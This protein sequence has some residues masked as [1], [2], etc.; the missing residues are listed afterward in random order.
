MKKNLFIFWVQIHQTRTPENKPTRTQK[1]AISD[2]NK[3]NSM[4]STN[5]K[6]VKRQ[7]ISWGETSAIDT[8]NKRSAPR[9]CQEVLYLNKKRADEPLER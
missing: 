6:R 7:A 8:T 1:T 5:I 3:I 4:S 9:I 2:D